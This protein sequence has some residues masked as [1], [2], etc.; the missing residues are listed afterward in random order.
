MVAL[1]L[2]ASAC[3]LAHGYGSLHAV[4]PQAPQPAARAA[5][6]VSMVERSMVPR[7]QALF[8]AFALTATALPAVA[9]KP[10]AANPD[11]KWISG[12]SDPLRPTSKDKPDGTKKDG[13]YIRCLNDCVPRKQGPPGPNQKD[14]IDCLDA[15][16]QECCFTY[17]QCTYSIRK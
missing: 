8:S 17:E 9:A 3:A 13:S 4:A 6:G 14:R 5:A 2:L 10:V 11:A 15:C 7:R 12:K 16:Q 1:S